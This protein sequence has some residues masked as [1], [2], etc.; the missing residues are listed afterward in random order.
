VDGKRLVTFDWSFG[1]M[2]VVA[3]GCPR[4]A[5]VFDAGLLMQ[6]MAADAGWKIRSI[7]SH[8]AN[9]AK[10]VPVAGVQVSIVGL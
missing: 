8:I 7:E 10:D 6:I 4:R 1:V 5:P 2:T 3:Y 9:V